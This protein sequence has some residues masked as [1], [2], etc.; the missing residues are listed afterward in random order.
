MKHFKKGNEKKKL[1]LAELVVAHLYLTP[2]RSC[3]VFA[4][5]KLEFSHSLAF[6]EG[7]C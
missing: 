6:S 2:T 3:Q 7:V 5:V 4:D 1:K